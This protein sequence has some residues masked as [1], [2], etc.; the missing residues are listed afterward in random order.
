MYSHIHMKPDKD[1]KIN[2]GLTKT[3]D[4]EGVSDFDHFPAFLL[5]EGEKITEVKYLTRK[6][7]EDIY[8]HTQALL[9]ELDKREVQKWK[10][11]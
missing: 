4:F 5:F 9:Q 10:T 1:M 7:L 8:F 3:G 2:S 6:H 11:F